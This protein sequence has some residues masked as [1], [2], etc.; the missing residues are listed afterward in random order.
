MGQ[1]EDRV[2]IYYSLSQKQVQLVEEKFI[3]N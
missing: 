2:T 3:A 1:D